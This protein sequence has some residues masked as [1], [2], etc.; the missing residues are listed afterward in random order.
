MRK[1]VAYQNRIV[2]VKL[3]GIFLEN[4][5]VH[6]H[7]AYCSLQSVFPGEATFFGY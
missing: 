2:R 5:Y 7:M 1:W 3:Y 4:I 6:V